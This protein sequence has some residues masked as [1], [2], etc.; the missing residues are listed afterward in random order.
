MIP[1]RKKI[2]PLYKRR[3]PTER[4]CNKNN[5]SW[6]L[7]YIAPPQSRKFHPLL[8]PPP[9]TP[10]KRSKFEALRSLGILSF[11]ELS[12]CCA[13][14]TITKGIRLLIFFLASE[15]RGGFPVCF[16]L[17]FFFFLFKVSYIFL[18]FLKLRI[19]PKEAC[20][21]ALSKQRLILL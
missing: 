14:S 11:P 13:N 10:P 4:R 5:S 7:S 20:P 15:G 2:C 8:F 18:A 19:S 12:V 3:Q 16:F 21:G 6:F 1:P 9:P 17:F